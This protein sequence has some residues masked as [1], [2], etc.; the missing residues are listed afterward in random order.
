MDFELIKKKLEKLQS[1]PQGS[2]KKD[3]WGP[4][5]EKAVHEVRIVPIKG[6]NDP[7]RERAFYYNIGKYR[8]LVSPW[9]SFEKQD[10]IWEFRK[11]LFDKGTDDSVALAKQLSPKSRYFAPIIVR[12]KEGDGVKWWGFSKTVYMYLLSKL[13]DEDYGNYIDA[14]EGRDIK[15]IVT[16]VQGR[17]YPDIDV[18]LKP[19]TSQLAESDKEIKEL[20]EGISDF[21]NIEFLKAKSYEELEE[22]LLE[23]QAEMTDEPSVEEIDSG[24]EYKGKDKEEKPAS[25]VH[26]S[27][28]DAFDD[29][30]LD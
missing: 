18:E 14:K 10:P 24:S 3:T 12:G 28:D 19:R 2:G 6:V 17:A 26:K 27:I 29:L 7:F 8:S 11:T 15:V 30:G 5:I 4:G 22:I 13:I 25:G 9:A 1:G 20:M 16:P 23:W 21:D